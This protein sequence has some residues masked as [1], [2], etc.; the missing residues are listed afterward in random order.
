MQ[1]LAL[2]SGRIWTS[3]TGVTGLGGV[4]QEVG[5]GELSLQNPHSQQATLTLGLYQL[6]QSVALGD[7]RIYARVKYGIGAANQTVLL[8]WSTGNSIT[9][10][11]GKLT[12]TAVQTDEQG[13]PAIKLPLGYAT[14][15]TRVFNSG[16]V[17]TASLA[18][19]PRS[20]LGYPT[21]TQTVGLAPIGPITFRSPLRVKRVQV[22]DSKGQ[23][24]TDLVAIVSGA[25]GFNKFD[26]ANAADSAIRTHGVVVQGGADVTLSSAVGDL[27]INLCWLL[28]G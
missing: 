5:M 11:C 25:L 17:L 1:D 18:A 15:L 7:A 19:G 2:Q 23:A 26:L 12:V 24:V 10:P 20:S 3:P 27:G 13:A 22:G 6:D 9:L 8:D 14:N 21:L 28:D 4:G 16:V